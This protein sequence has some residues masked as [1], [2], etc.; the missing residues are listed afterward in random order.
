MEWGAMGTGDTSTDTALAGAR[1]RLI[2]SEQLTPTRRP[3]TQPAAR[4]R[5]AHSP[6][7]V[8]LDTLDYLTATVDEVIT[9]TYAAN[10]AAGPAPADTDELYTW[11]AEHTTDVTGGQRRALDAMI[12]RQ[13]LEHALRLD[14]ERV[15]R[16]VIR[17][18]ACERCDRWGL[19]WD[20]KEWR[21]KCTYNKC[22]DDQGR[23]TRWTLAQLAEQHVARIPR[24]AA[25]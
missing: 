24:R 23:P 5:A 21:I 11:Y 10:P 20:A 18:H 12:W 1:M 14:D 17:P 6:A 25:T 13:S 7:P 19:F 8:D 15:V 16:T 22:V 2:R 4:T 3:S 9:T